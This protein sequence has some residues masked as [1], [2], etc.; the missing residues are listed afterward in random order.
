ME[1]LKVKFI[2]VVTGLLFS[3][4]SLAVFASKEALFHKLAERGFSHVVELDNRLFE[5]DSLNGPGEAREIV[6]NLATMKPEVF[7]EER[8]PKLDFKLPTSRARKWVYGDEYAHAYSISDVM[9]CYFVKTKVYYKEYEK[10]YIFPHSVEEVVE[11]LYDE[12]SSNQHPL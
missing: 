4:P 7:T 11:A 12:V 6:I 9:I 8:L 10:C 3:L 2:F 5:M 1:S